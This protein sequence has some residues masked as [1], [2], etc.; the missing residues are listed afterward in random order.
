VDLVAGMRE[1]VRDYDLMAI[2]PRPGKMPLLK[3]RFAF[4]ARHP[5]IGELNDA[6]D[7]EID[8]PVNFPRELPKV[9]ETGNRIPRT[10]FYH[11]NQHDHSLCLGSPLRLRFLLAEKPSLLGFAEKCLVP[12]LAGISHKL[13][14]GKPLPFGELEHGAPGALAD[15]QLL[16]G[17]KTPE[18]A[19]ATLQLLGKKKRIANKLPCPCG[20]RLRLGRCV[21]R[22]RLR[23]FRA[24]ANRPW[25]RVQYQ[26]MSRCLSP[27]P[28][29]IPKISS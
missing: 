17:L 1:F 15:Y 6:F 27:I 4:V 26:E 3:G 21:F 2:R 5:D 25:Y 12:Y 13:S 29:A 11:V 8:V 9:T 22:D 10:R 18:Q 14:T 7:L 19:L 28:T 23:H 20:C 16:F 24:L